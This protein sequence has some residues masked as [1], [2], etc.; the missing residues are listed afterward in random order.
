MSQLQHYEQ[1]LDLS[2]RMLAHAQAAQWEQVIALSAD[3]ATAVDTLKAL[4][5][6][7]AADANTQVQQALLQR[8]LDNDT[9]IRDL[10]TPE[11]QRLGG[12]M[13]STKRQRNVLQAY[14]GPSV[15]Q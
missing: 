1:L 7:A 11:L 4:P 12:L 14:C 2:T 3:Y 9:A 15:N 10:A 5:V 13:G 8:I 6:P